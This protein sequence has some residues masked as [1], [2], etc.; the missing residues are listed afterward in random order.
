LYSVQW[1]CKFPYMLGHLSYF[2]SYKLNYSTPSRVTLSLF[3]EGNFICHFSVTFPVIKM[4]C[5]FVLTFKEGDIFINRSAPFVTVK[6]YFMSIVLNYLTL[7][8]ASVDYLSVCNIF[9][10]ICYFL[11]SLWNCRS[12]K[13][14]SV[15]ETLKIGPPNYGYCSTTREYVGD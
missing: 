2:N 3:K 10:V 11:T 12:M 6:G 5:H 8:V 9:I 15:T 1:K 14:S 13:N 7:S 4:W